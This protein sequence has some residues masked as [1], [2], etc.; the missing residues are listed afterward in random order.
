M[1]ELRFNATGRAAAVIAV[2][3][4]VAAA[5]SAGATPSPA[6][7][8]P[9]VTSASATPGPTAAPSSSAPAA[10]PVTAAKGTFH[11]VDGSGSGSVAL[12][13]LADG[14]FEVVFEDFNTPSAAHVNVIVVAAKD[15]TR[16]QDVDPKA[17]V[18]LGPLKGTTGMQD[19]TFPADMAANAMTYH[20]VVLW[21]TQMTHA[22]AA[23]PLAGS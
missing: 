8:P 12:E 15:V 10:T 9:A 19:Y 20:T 7:A 5:C 23:A 21:D 1:H 13:H 16:D 18:D 11:N 6:V 17:I 3:G 2:V 22:V 4:M 14:S